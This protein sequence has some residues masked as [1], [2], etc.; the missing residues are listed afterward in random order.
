MSVVNK[1]KKAQQLIN[2]SLKKIMKAIFQGNFKE[3]GIKCNI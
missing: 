2:S 3:K 1:E